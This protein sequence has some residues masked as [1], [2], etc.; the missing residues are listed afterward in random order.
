MARHP[1]TRITKSNKQALKITYMNFTYLTK[2]NKWGQG[3]S[4][5]QMSLTCLVQ[6]ILMTHNIILSRQFSDLPFFFGKDKFEEELEKEQGAIKLAREIQRGGYDIRASIFRRHFCVERRQIS[7]T[8]R[9]IRGQ[10]GG[11]Q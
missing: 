1:P 8:G 11:Y 9:R 10:V 3:K 4:S 7:G 5:F 2:F 6:V